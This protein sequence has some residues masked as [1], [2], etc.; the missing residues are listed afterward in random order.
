MGHEKANRQAIARTALCIATAAAALALA[1]SVAGASAQ[2]SEEHPYLPAHSL[3]DQFT[4][5]SACGVTTD[6]VGDVYVADYA[7]HKVSIYSP[8]ASKI[9]EFEVPGF[10]N[11]PC[12][13]AVDP[14]TGALY[15]GE[16]KGKVV[17]E[18]PS[19]YPPEASTTYALE[20]SA[21]A[22]GVIVPK[23]NHTRGIAFDAANQRLYV[24]EANINEIQEYTIPKTSYK[25]KF[26]SCETASIATTATTAEITAALE[27]C[28]G[29][30]NVVLESVS[31]T[32]KL[33]YFR[34]AL[35]RKDVPLL[36]VVTSVHTSA[37]TVENGATSKVSAFQPN[38]ALV[39]NEIG[40]DLAPGHEYFGV[41]VDENDGDVYVTDIANRKAFIL[42]PAGT[43][44]VQEVT[45]AETP[46]G[47][48]SE[49][50]Y[51]LAVDQS[52]GNLLVYYSPSN[53][54][55]NG[56]A[57]YEFAPSGAYLS[58]IG[59]EF[60]SGLLHLKTFEPDAVAVDNG[61]SSP[62]QGD[63]YVSS[64]DSEADSVYA[65]GPA[66]PKYALSLSTSGTGTGSLKCSENG[67]AA[68]TCLAKYVEGA[69]VEVIPTAAAGSEFVEWSGDCSGSGACV[70]TMGGAHSVGAVFNL[71]PG[72]TLSVTKSGN[73]TGSVA[74][75]V[76]GLGGEKI[77]CGA[78]C[79]E[80]FSE[81][82]LVK[83]TG[84]PGPNIE[85]ALWSGCDAVNG[86]DE[87]E[88]TMSA[89]KAVEAVFKRRVRALTLSASGPGSLLAQCEEAPSSFQ[90]CARPLG[91]LDSGTKVKVT[92][93]PKA[94]AELKSFSG[95]GSA[96]GCAGEG[97]P[98]TFTITEDSSVGAEFSAVSRALTIQVGGKGL[99]Q[100]NCQVNGGA[101]D[102]PCASS[103][104]NGTQ[105]KLIAV[106]AGGSEFAGFSAGSGSASTCATSPCEFT[107][108]AD[109]SLA[110]TFIHTGEKT[111]KIATTGTGTGQVDCKVNGG[112]TDSPCAASYAAGTQLK[113]I[114]APGNSS[115][116][117]GFSAGSGS[118]SACAT[119]P[120]E[121]KLEANS[122]L[123]ARFDIFTHTLSV[124]LEGEGEV[125]CEVNEGPAEPCA[126]K[127]P[128]D[129]ELALLARP[130]THWAFQGWGEG[131]DSISCTGTGTCGPFALEADSSVTASFT[132]PSGPFALPDERGWEM[133]SPPE[134]HGALVEPIGED[135]LI[136]AAA[137]GNGLAYVTRTALEAE[138]AG[139]LVYDTQ[140]AKRSPAG[141]WSSRELALPHASISTGVSVGEGWEHRFF[142]RDLSRAFVQPF[143]DFLPCE[144]ETGE[145]QPCLSPNATEQTAF[146]ASN[147][148]SETKQPCATNCYTPLATGAPGYA[149]VP[150]GTEFGKSYLGGECPP[151]LYCGPR[152]LDA[153]PDATHALFESYEA[154][155][156]SPAPGHPVPVDSLYEWSGEKPA[157]EQLRLISVLPGNASGE[158]RPAENPY[159]GSDPGSPSPRHAI[160][161][162]GSRVVFLTFVRSGGSEPHIYLRENATEPQS[163]LN[164][165]GEC[166]EPEKACTIQLDKGLSGTPI[167]QDADVGLS[168]FFFS[169]TSSETNRGDLY[170]YDLA[171]ETLTRLTE[172]AK[173]LGVAV[174]ASEDG[175]SVYFAG[176]CGPGKCANLYLMHRGAGGWEAPKLVAAGLSGNDEDAWGNGHGWFPDLTARVSPNGRYLAFMSERSL[177][178]YDNRDAQTGQRDQEVYEYDATSET[179]TCAS[180]NPTG[181]RPQGVSAEQIDTGHGGIAGGF[182][183]LPSSNRVAANIPGWT[184][185][186]TGGSSNYQSRY[187]S[188][189]G[190]L[191]F[192]AADALAP[193][194]SNGTE[195]VYQ[196]EPEGVGNCAPASSSGSVVFESASGACVGLISSGLSGRESAFLDASESGDD[197]FFL[198]AAKLGGRDFDSAYDVYDARVGG[199]EAEEVKPVECI[200][201][202]CQQ[203]ANPPEDP[204]PGSLSFSGPEEG[205]NHAEGTP[206]TSRCAKG[207][208]RRAGRC[209]A[210]HHKKARHK[211]RAN[212]KRGGLK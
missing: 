34:G 162:D 40:R 194:D 101:T 28:T 13:I 204:T 60:D 36:E 182:L 71:R 195:D 205:P 39:S 25:L 131:T 11:G 212:P 82:Q 177:T 160:S 56:A 157:A 144:S 22:N 72:K 68:T 140:L 118:A 139:A 81:G 17:K 187:L 180:C 189:S 207:K 89:A 142:S 166:T 38:G 87:C 37:K 206:T 200:G 148:D 122:S 109:S 126:A 125:E 95:T 26:E 203:P 1:L 170:E 150:P 58:K 183:V 145:A 198:T 19:S 155:T 153:T 103:Y 32:K 190:R 116:F 135:W 141:G 21:G 197:V 55:D 208:V 149:N 121:F 105:L 61:A 133:V 46:T 70:V 181:A 18:K 124:L 191:F 3:I 31:G 154:L 138:P 193:K 202:A 156:E 143:G 64:R 211:K 209:I 111:L 42:N 47:K 174:G 16:F 173:L 169:E 78:H 158:A 184:P 119:A 104:P 113:L 186:I 63:V 6:S 62:N 171:T 41:G 110:A 152:F 134:K 44:I 53:Q 178:G 33:V 185:S 129:T 8:G 151:K 27:A 4:R 107:I 127:Y 2:A 100:V 188:N 98:C 93:T 23:A 94:G 196:Y 97:S 67:G 179:L 57:V 120:C 30:G 175:N 14:K 128:K 54:S 210:R 51:G 91:E 77:E 112:A 9:T 84:A 165:A 199:G 49:F 114:P 147:F 15:V 5:A 10:G 48:L 115:E 161:P 96:S 12:S 137:D 66:L 117:T 164:G 136:Q 102:E 29:A 76:A 7:T 168:R 45:G 201:D 172:G 90:A 130:K 24:A 79:S 88:V 83:L 65:F 50:I 192:N 108:N 159:I 146:L 99:G 163:A 20:E 80:N 73:G 86:F 132:V 176:E 167:F 85:A 123:T 43:A 69:E 35:A 106:P 59:P 75:D 74:S 92:A 52:D